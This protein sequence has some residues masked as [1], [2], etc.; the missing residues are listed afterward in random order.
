MQN[1]IGEWMYRKWEKLFSQHIPLGPRIYGSTFIAVLAFS[2]TWTFFD[3][4]GTYFSLIVIFS[5]IAISLFA[6][7]RLALFYAVA[8]SLAGDYFFIEPIGSVFESE[9]SVEHFIIVVVASSMTAFLV[10]SL[11]SAFTRL[12]LAKREADE[13]TK[14]ARQA[15]VQMERV[16]AL[17]SHDLRNPL[18]TAK[19]ASQLLLEKPNRVERQSFLAM[20]SRNLDR[21]DDL[22]QSLLDVASIRKGMS[23][24][25]QFQHC[26]LRSQV[27]H[28]VEE[29]SLG[30][31]GRIVLIANE[32]IWGLWGSDGIRRGVENLI[33][34]ALKYGSPDFPITVN[35]SRNKKNEA[36]L[37]VHNHGNEIA[38]EDQARL[39]DSFHR[40]ESAEKSSRRG[41]G[42]GLAVVRA[43][44][45]AHGGTITVESGTG[46]G[47]NFILTLPGHQDTK[48]CD[49]Q[50][51]PA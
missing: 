34:N 38:A 43:V 11:R 1:F 40:A 3:R 18:A 36:I 5:V 6:G 46:A 14:D 20:I 37:S 31:A 28:L 48:N 27:S 4:T 47:T 41:W 10:G 21:A 24:P 49:K 50:L 29:L 32:P 15:S 16:L 25:L 13:A 2:L 45:D 19:M 35:L 33:T 17:V 30:H 44:A 22:I 8:L 42:L 23:I 39:F 51:S 9:K 7:N 12:A 26:D